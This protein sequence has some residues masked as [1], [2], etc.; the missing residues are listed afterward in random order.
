MRTAFVWGNGI[1]LGLQ[2]KNNQFERPIQKHANEDHC[3]KGI[4]HGSA[5]IQP[6]KRCRPLDRDNVEK[7]KMTKN[8][9][10]IPLL[11]KLL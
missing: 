5:M 2:G 10:Q 8:A 4:I 11:S 6:A 3:P 1:Y 9:S 7:I